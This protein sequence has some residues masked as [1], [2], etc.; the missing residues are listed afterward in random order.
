MRYFGF[1]FVNHRSHGSLKI[2]EHCS[3]V[4]RSEQVC[5]EEHRQF[6]IT[7][8]APQDEAAL[9]KTGPHR[10]TSGTPAPEFLFFSAL[11][12]D[13]LFVVHDNVFS[14]QRTAWP[15]QHVFDLVQLLGF[16]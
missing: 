7:W 11:K 6:Q 16:R 2:I 15:V 3:D 4:N 12:R 8:P 1:R 10:S 14:N 13:R 5:T 9:K